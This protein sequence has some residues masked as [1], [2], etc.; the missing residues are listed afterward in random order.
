MAATSSGATKN[1]SGLS[2]RRWRVR[3]RS[4]TP[5]MTISE[6]WIPAGPRCLAIASASERCAALAGANAAVAYDEFKTE[7]TA[8]VRKCSAREILVSWAGKP[9]AEDVEGDLL[10]PYVRQ[11]ELIDCDDDEKFHAINDFLLASVDR[12]NWSKAGLVSVSGESV[13]LGHYLNEN[14]YVSVSPNLGTNT[15]G[16]PSQVASIQYFIRR[17]LTITTATMSDGSRQVFLNVKKRY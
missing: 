12:T 2:G 9:R 7:I 5:S 3:G 4:T 6:T 15:S 11:L 13:G 14:T 8:F 17:W 10:R 16:T 1:A